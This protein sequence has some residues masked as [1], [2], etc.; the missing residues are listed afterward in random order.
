MNVMIVDDEQVIRLGLEKIMSRLELDI[1]IVG[2]HSNGM[3]ALAQLSKLTSSD[4]DVL[5]TDIKMPM[6]N[7]LKLIELLHERM[8]NLPVIVLSGFNDFE[9]ARTALRFGVSDYL[10]K[11]IDKRELIQVLSSI[12]SQRKPRA[13]PAESTEGEHYVVDQIK[14]ILDKEYEKPFELDQL[15]SRISMNP[16][17][18]SRLFKEKTSSTITDYIIQLRIEKAKQFLQDHPHLKNYEISQLV[19]YNDPVYFNKL[20]KKT[21]GMTPMEYRRRSL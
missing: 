18:I 12:R 9:Y 14:T 19:G 20:F 13:L 2:S 4:V 15:A 10:L 5:I 17:Y 16:S 7:G 1:E 6:M 11:P 3:D 21:T 8:P